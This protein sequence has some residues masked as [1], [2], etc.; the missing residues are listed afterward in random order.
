[1]MTL[2]PHTGAALHGEIAYSEEITFGML[3]TPTGAPRGVAALRSFLPGG[4]TPTGRRTAEFRE[5]LEEVG[6]AVEIAR[7]GFQVIAAAARKAKAFSAHVMRL[8]SADVPH[9]LIHVGVVQAAEVASR[10]RLPIGESFPL[11]FQDAFR[12][13]FPSLSLLMGTAV[14]PSE[15]LGLVSRMLGK[16]AESAAVQALDAHVGQLLPHLNTATLRTADANVRVTEMETLI[17][18]MLADDSTPKT[19]APAGDESAAGAKPIAAIDS[20]A[21]ARVLTQPMVLAMLTKL[22]PLNVSPIGARVGGVHSVG[23]V[24]W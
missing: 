9:L 2:P 18:A 11:Y 7:P 24:G 5:S 17:R 3:S 14:E 23:V 12:T 1:M 13:A 20:Q 19:T 10:Y 4:Y 21:W 6:D 8:M 15:A 22:E 16:S